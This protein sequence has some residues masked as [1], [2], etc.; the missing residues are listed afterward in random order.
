[1]AHGRK[2]ACSSQ[3][4]P[5]AS[6]CGVNF[7]SGHDCSHLSPATK[8]AA[9]LFPRHRSYVSRL[10]AFAFSGYARDSGGGYRL[11]RIATFWRRLLPES[12]LQ[13]WPKRLTEIATKINASPIYFATLFAMLSH[14]FGAGLW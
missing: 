6:E 13:R 7:S 5:L 12:A 4:S 11:T 1:M 8:V 3:T 14:H 10:G 2:A 9:G